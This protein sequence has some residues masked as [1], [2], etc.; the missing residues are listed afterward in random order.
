MLYL[1]ESKY[2]ITVTP[3]RY[4]AIYILFFGAVLITSVWLW[5]P[6]WL[7]YQFVIQLMLSGLLL[8]YLRQ[9]LTRRLQQPFIV[10]LSPDGQ[11]RA[12]SDG[13]SDDH[14]E[15]GWQNPGI[16]WQL[17]SQSRATD[18]MLWLHLTNFQQQRQWVC[19]FRD[20]V[21]DEDYRRLCLAIKYQQKNT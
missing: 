19:I 18:F 6:N 15:H 2:R 13:F 3:A 5:Q 10:S 14:S 8:I 11:F 4:R 7:P 9:Q 17:S 16:Q 21:S 12:L 20:E 1:P